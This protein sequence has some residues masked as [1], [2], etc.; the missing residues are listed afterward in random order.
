MTKPRSISVPGYEGRS[1]RVAAN[2]L[3]RII[4]VNN[5]QVS[6]LFVLCVE[7]PAERLSPSGQP[8]CSTSRRPPE[9]ADAC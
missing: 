7:N 1:A 3:I 5:C 8:V 6:D 4:D 9:N 2:S